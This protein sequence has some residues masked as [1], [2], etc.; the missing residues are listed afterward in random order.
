M[1]SVRYEVARIPG[2]INSY[3]ALLESTS[4]TESTDSQISTPEELRKVQK[5]EEEIL[6]SE[7]ELAEFEEGAIKLRTILKSGFEEIASRPR[8]HP[9]FEKLKRLQLLETSLLHSVW[10]EMGDGEADSQ[11]EAIKKARANKE[12]VENEKAPEVVDRKNRKGKETAKELYLKIAQVTHP[13]KVSDPA[14]TKYF[15]QACAMYKK[16]DIRG[17]KTILGVLKGKGLKAKLEELKLKRIQ[18]AEKEKVLQAEVKA[19]M[20]GTYREVFELKKRGRLIEAETICL[21]VFS[22]LI[23]QIEDSL[24]KLRRKLSVFRQTKKE[25]S[26]VSGT[27]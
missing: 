23:E 17:L 4:E 14:V 10:R 3:T 24:G 2:S 18:L 15:Y 7:K 13:D 20:E 1:E 6:A 9:T 12:S 22:S 5:L 19:L 25:R 21:N 8:V 26:V 27:E 11:E 16:G